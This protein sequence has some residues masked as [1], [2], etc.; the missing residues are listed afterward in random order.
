ML[1]TL[2]TQDRTEVAQATTNFRG[3]FGFTGLA[4]GIYVVVESD[5]P[6]FLSSTPNNYTVRIAGPTPIP[7]VSFGDYR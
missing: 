2:Y 4:P 3:Q 7:E 5:P 6:N 1:V